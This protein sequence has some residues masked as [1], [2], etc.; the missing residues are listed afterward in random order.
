MN[1]FTKEELEI[2]CQFFTNAIEDFLEPDS[3]YALRD[4]IQ[5]LIDSYCDHQYLIPNF[6]IL[7]HCSTCKTLV[8]GN[9]IEDTNNHEHDM[10]CRFGRILDE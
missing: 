7:Q 5:S 3:T 10:T 4:K 6:G 8:K 9:L 2:I 1:Y